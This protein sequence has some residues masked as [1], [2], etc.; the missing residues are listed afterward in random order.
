[1]IVFIVFLK[2]FAGSLHLFLFFMPYFVMFKRWLAQVTAFCFLLTGPVLTSYLTSSVNEQAA[3]WC[4]SSVVQ[5]IL[6]GFAV[7]YTEL[8]KQPIIDQ[9]HHPGGYGE[10][11][12]T[13]KVLGTPENGEKQ[14][15]KEVELEINKLL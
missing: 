15:G 10:S 14:A 7:R 2:I 3:I 11:P 6:F 5:A 4:F 12:L 9:I 13:Y 8:H 1:M